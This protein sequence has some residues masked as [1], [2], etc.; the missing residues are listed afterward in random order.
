ML[1]HLL[2]LASGFAPA[3]SAAG[4]QR[5]GAVLDGGGGGAD[6]GIDHRMLLWPVPARPIYALAAGT[7]AGMVG[8]LIVV[9]GPSKSR[10]AA[11]LRGGA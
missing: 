8:E 5:R 11:L 9:I 10:G 7:V 4:D 3:R 1:P 2:P 6:P